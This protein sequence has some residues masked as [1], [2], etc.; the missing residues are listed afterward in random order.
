M[1]TEKGQWIR[2]NCADPTYVIRPSANTFG[3]QVVVYGEVEDQ[4]ATEYLLKWGQ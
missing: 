3:Q 2:A 1:Q 4:L